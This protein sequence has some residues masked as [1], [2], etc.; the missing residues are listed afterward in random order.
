LEPLDVRNHSN[1]GLADRLGRRATTPATV[2][3]MMISGALRKTRVCRWVQLVSGL[4]AL[5]RVKRL[6]RQA[7]DRHGSF[8]HASSFQ[9]L[10]AERRTKSLRLWKRLGP[11]GSSIVTVQSTTARFA[12]K[13]DTDRTFVVRPALFVTPEMNSS[14]VSMR[15]PSARR[16]ANAGANSSSKKRLSPP[17]SACQFARSIFEVRRRWSRPQ[18]PCVAWCSRPCSFSESRLTLARVGSRA[19]VSAAGA[20]LASRDL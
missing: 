3:A 10:R 9:S 7:S 19:S 1:T 2:M 14:R 8:A 18:T 17:A 15:L 13:M 4:R 5:R 11:S 16:M 6:R 20:Y 12:S